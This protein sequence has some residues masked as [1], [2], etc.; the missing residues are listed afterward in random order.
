MGE[1][2]DQLLARLRAFQ[3]HHGLSGDGV[4]GSQTWTLLAGEPGTPSTPG[5]PAVEVDERGQDQDGAGE[6]EELQAGRRR[7]RSQA[8][9]RA[10]V[11]AHVHP[12]DCFIEYKNNRDGW[13]P[14]TG[15]GCAHWVAHQR[16]GPT[17]N[18]NVCQRG[19]KYRV[20]D[21]LGTLT[22]VSANLSGARI[23]DV[24][25]APAGQSHIGIVREVHRDATTNAVTSV[26][27]E[28]DSSASGGVVRQDKDTGSIH[29]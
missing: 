23:G 15:T 4:A 24:W 2:D 6:A 19:F 10:L 29:R 28:N 27:V 1:F 5:A 14:I 8:E 26:E 18:S 22:Q 16:G 9:A 12:R 7:P 11:D 20:T 3:Q 17:G 25:S 21:V 13:G